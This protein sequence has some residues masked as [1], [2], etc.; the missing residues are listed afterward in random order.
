MRRSTGRAER[1][2]RDEVR[3]RKDEQ[4]LDLVERKPSDPQ[5]RNPF[6]KCRRISEQPVEKK[7]RKQTHLL[8]K[9]QEL[10]LRRP[11]ITQQQHVDV[12]PQPH[13]IRQHL[14]APPK[15]QTRDRLFDVEV[16]EDGWCDGAGEAFVETFGAGDSAEFFFLLSGKGAG[17]AGGRGGE[18]GVE[19]EA[20][21]TEVGRSEGGSGGGC[22]L[23]KGKGWTGSKSKDVEEGGQGNGGE[24]R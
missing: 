9:L 5:Q 24:K 6:R 13:P 11:R 20:E 15:Q 2:E 14:L 1:Q 23:A 17:G 18:G 16:A 8:H 10:T 22:F 3:V 21:Y 19:L 4:W 7:R 12:S